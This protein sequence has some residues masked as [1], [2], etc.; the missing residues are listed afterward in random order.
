MWAGP[1]TPGWCGWWF[2]APPP[3]CTV[4]LPPG[5]VKF[6]PQVKAACAPASL[7]HM[8]SQCFRRRHFSFVSLFFTDTR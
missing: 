2:I 4:A 1:P 7:L 8:R 3:P 6:R 5:A